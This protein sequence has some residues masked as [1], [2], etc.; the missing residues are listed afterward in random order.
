[1]AQEQSAVAQD[2]LNRIRQSLLIR[3]AALS[4]NQDQLNELLGTLQ[5]NDDI[6]FTAA[7]TNLGY[8]SGAHDVH[9]FDLFPRPETL[10]SGN[11]AV[12][13]VTYVAEHETFRNTLLTAGQSRQFRASYTGWGCLTQIVALTE[14]VDPTK[15][16]TVTVFDMCEKLG[17]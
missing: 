14:Y 2:A 1:M 5:R 4:G 3:Q 12:A 17:W 7:A 15:P 9:R 8:K 6:Q 13:F 10:P 11:D 16:P